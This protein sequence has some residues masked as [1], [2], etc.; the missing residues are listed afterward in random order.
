FAA[1][2]FVLNRA[3]DR[4][5]AG[6]PAPTASGD[7]MQP[8]YRGDPGQA[9][10]LAFE[11]VVIAGPDGPLPAWFL[12]G[13]ARLGAIY[14]HGGGGARGDGYRLVRQLTE[15]GLPVLMAS[16]RGDAGA[17]PVEAAGF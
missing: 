9:L 6:A 10:D 13:A 1:A 11:E 12:P 3:A 17:P 4:F 8:G 7:P 14:V 15:A 5:L 16:Y 2:G